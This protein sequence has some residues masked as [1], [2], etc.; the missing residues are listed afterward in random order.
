MKQTLRTSTRIVCENRF[1]ATGGWLPH[2]MR[3]ID[4]YLTGWV[5]HKVLT[6]ACDTG[7]SKHTLEYV[8]VKTAPI[9]KETIEGAVRGGHMHVLHWMIGR[10]DGRGPWKEDFGHMLELAAAHGHLDAVK[11]LFKRGID[12]YTLQKTGKDSTGYIEKCWLY[13]HCTAAALN[14]AA[15]HGHLEV[16][17]WIHGARTDTCNRDCSPMSKA[18]ENGHLA[19]AQ[20]LHTTKSEKCSVHTINTAAKN[21]HLQVLQWLD[22]N[23][24]FMCTGDAMIGAAANGHLEVVKWLHQAHHECC[25]NHAMGLAASNGHLELAEWLYENVYRKCQRSVASISAVNSAGA[26]RLDVLRWMHEHFRRSFS[27]HDMYAAASNGRMDVITWLHENRNEGCSV[28]AMRG[29]SQNGHLEVLKWLYT[30]YP[31]AFEP[32]LYA[33]INRAAGNGHLKIVRW[34][35]ETRPDLR[36]TDAMDNAATSGHLDIFL[37]LLEHRT[38]GIS[39]YTPY[40]AGFIEVMCHFTS[41]VRRIGQSNRA[42]CDQ[43][44]MLQT[45]F[46]QRP[47]FL[48]RCLQRL[49]VIAC[50]TGNVSLLDWVNQFGLELKSTEPI[51]DAVSRGYVKMLQFFFDHGFE[52]TDPDLLEVAVKGGQLE[53]VR[54]LSEHGYAINSLELLKIRGKCMSVPMTR[55]LVEHGSLLDLSTATTLVVEYRHIEI[56]WW[57]AE[58]DQ[59]HLV[60]DALENND[61]EVLWWVLTHT[62]FQDKSAQRSIRDA[63]HGC[64]EDIQQW[65]EESLRTVESCRWC[66]STSIKRQ[67]EEIEDKCLPGWK[68]KRCVERFGG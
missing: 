28:Y 49:A 64:P 33:V 67:N 41:N 59:C 11:W 13:E 16:V 8:F 44:K 29:A 43:L 45:V 56:A 51:R 36:T 14:R 15:E 17:K 9:W 34:L 2:V 58:T 63:I 35:H 21:G 7:A 54:L 3:C 39:A 40:N 68:R 6:A 50:K 55:W 38:E 42:T 57:V 1:S 61:R 12:S 48:R 24:L 32:G 25:S 47:A 66:F 19:I 23:Q 46:E 65:F 20:W 37:Y 4:N 5:S 27:I 31:N 22:A 26:G 60:L 53:I 30:H 18:V 62:Q 10:E 52:I